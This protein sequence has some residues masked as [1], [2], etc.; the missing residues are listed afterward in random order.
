MHQ[1]NMIK[2]NH[3]LKVTNIDAYKMKW[4]YLMQWA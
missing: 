1:E 2:K 4:K 3:A